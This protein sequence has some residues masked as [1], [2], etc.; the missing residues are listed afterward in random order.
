MGIS[1]SEVGGTGTYPAHPVFRGADIGAN[2]AIPGGARIND[3][4]AGGTVMYPVNPVF[5][6]TD[7]GEVAANPGC[8]RVSD[9]EG[10][11]I[12]AG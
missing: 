4:E 8:A 11:R 5:R 9:S 10:S 6:V 3:S 12:D 2:A 1:D 7:I